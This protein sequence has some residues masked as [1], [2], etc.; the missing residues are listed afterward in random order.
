MIV[1]IESIP[2]ILYEKDIQARVFVTENAIYQAL[3][4]DPLFFRR[5]CLEKRH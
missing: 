3:C 5:Q 2:A 4:C 1:R